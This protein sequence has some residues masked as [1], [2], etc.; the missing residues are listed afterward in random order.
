V[1]ECAF[2]IPGDIGLPT[3][4]YAYDR[5]LLA[6]MP[7][8]GVELVHLPLP[9]SF[10]FPAEQDLDLAGSRL[11]AVPP[12]RALLIDGLAYGALPER[13]IRSIRAPIIALVH[14][15]L[16][17]EA[18]LGEPERERLIDSERR[19]LALARHIVVTSA[20]TA[21]LLVQDFA[22]TSER[23]TVAVPG[24]EPAPR[25]RGSGG[26]SVHILAVGAVMPRK[27][28]DLLVEAL[29]GLTPLAWHLTIAG[30]L[31]RSPETARALEAQIARLGLDERVTLAGAV[32][33]AAL[34]RLYD[35]TDLFVMSSHFEGY[36]MVLAEALA[37]GL[38][39]VTTT[40]G[41]A[42]ET[43]PDAA[44]IKVMPG[45][46]RA[47]MWVLGRALDEP[48]L[49]AAMADAAWSAA[50]ALPRWEATAT[51]VADVIRRVAR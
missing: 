4:G 20:A 37:H 9:G 41:A 18:G 21:R 5:R 27:G 6:L 39:I 26:P 38:P 30:A 34:A 24:V 29:A 36:G 16:G 42:G 28:Y 40:G 11:F 44:A 43:V 15:P 17:L 13:L 45:S 49:R 51:I 12:T 23:I 33:D 8:D 50:S 3:G 46:A 47:L 1:V 35:R 48:K 14:H 22:V 25:A 7:A 31:D 32:D 10:P 2:A 19:A